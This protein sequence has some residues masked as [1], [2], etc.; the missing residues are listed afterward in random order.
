[1]S[2]EMHVLEWLPAYALDILT[3][4]ETAQV[5]EHLATCAAC[6]DELHLYQVAADELPLALAQ[7]A[8]AP[9]LK[10]RL[11]KT[12]YARQKETTAPARLGRWSAWAAFLRRSLPV[13]GVALVAI[14][15]LG[16]IL[17][18]RR[19]NQVSGRN[20]TPMRLVALANTKDSPQAV[21]TL[22]LNPSGEYGSLVVDSLPV[23]D[24]GHQYQV[25]LKH[26]GV[27]I[28]AGVFSV[29]SGGY[30]SFQVTTPLPLNQYQTIGITIEPAGGSPDPT[31]SKVL[32]ANL[33]P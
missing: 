24:T 13:W 26:D 2:D 14:L 3:E 19:L 23:L 16:N 9:A 33:Q 5:V 31:G 15:A 8:P 18:W 22:M 10:D 7:T 12:I 4:A 20:V 27:R 29:N 11:M 30:A 6:R 1:M 28:S 17:F 25:W 32:G 21:G